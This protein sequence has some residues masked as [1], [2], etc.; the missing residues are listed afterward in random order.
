MSGQCAGKRQFGHAFGK[1]HHRGDGHRRVAANKDVDSKRLFRINRGLMLDPDAAM[2]LI[3]QSNLA[4]RLIIVAGQ[5][6]PVHAKVGFAQSGGADIFAVDLRQRDE[7]AAIVGPAFQLGQGSDVGL[8]SDA[9]A[10]YP[11]TWVAFARQSRAPANTSAAGA[12]LAMGRLSA[13]WPV[14]HFR[15]YRER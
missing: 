6:N 14:A 9:L 1:R 12:S 3:V 13:E 5:L 7:R 8:V 11:Q 15:T 4:I 2:N 10:R